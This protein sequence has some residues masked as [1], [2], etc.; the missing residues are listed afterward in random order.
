MLTQLIYKKCYKSVFRLLLSRY[1]NLVLKIMKF[2]LISYI[3]IICNIKN[4]V[5]FDLTKLENAGLNS[6]VFI[7]DIAV[8][9]NRAFLTVPRSTCQNNITN[10][11]LVEV[12]WKEFNTIL[13]VK[14]NKPIEQQL[15]AKCDELQNSV[16]LAKESFKSKLW[17]LDAGNEYCTPKIMVYNVFHNMFLDEVIDLRNIPRKGLN[18][19]IIENSTIPGNHRAFISSPGFSA[20]LVCDLEKLQ[21]KKIKMVTASNHPKSLMIYSMAFSKTSSDFYFVDKYTTQVYSA[22]LNNFINWKDKT[23]INTTFLGQLMGQS[24]GLETDLKNGLIYY[25]TRDYAVVRWIIGTPMAAENHNVLAQSYKR[26]PYVS[27]IFTDPQN[28]I[29]A[30]VNPFSP[31]NC[32]TDLTDLKK[33][34]RVAKIMRYN[35]LLDTFL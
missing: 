22:D 33:L 26:M 24:S 21:C 29:W 12:P 18:T 28:G 20:I 19:I 5:L 14:Y 4:I 9:F 34:D 32:N 15:W 11:T 23:S 31:E 3:F 2:L 8:Y 30:L 35:R 1:F 13:K 25:L 27:R 17:I 7:S 16:S 10:P 6:D